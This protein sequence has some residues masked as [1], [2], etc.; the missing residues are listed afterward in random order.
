MIARET[1]IALF[2]FSVTELLTYKDNCLGT[3][4][5]TLPGFYWA[6]N[7]RDS[8][9]NWHCC[10]ENYNAGVKCLFLT[11]ERVADRKRGRDI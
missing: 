8:G 2:G 5:F 10:V 3:W 9:F 7:D 11:A 4:V 6:K 1:T